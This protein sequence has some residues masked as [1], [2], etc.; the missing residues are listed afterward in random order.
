MTKSPYLSSDTRLADVIA[1]IQATATY[2][3]YQLPVGG[4]RGWAYRITGSPHYADGLEPV[5]LQHP[6]FFRRDPGG[7]WALVW[8]RQH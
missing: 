7:N 5:L 4:K 8:R 6:E 3:F 2:K 1:A